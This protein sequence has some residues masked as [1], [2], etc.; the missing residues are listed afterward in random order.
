MQAKRPFLCRFFQGIR[1]VRR[2]TERRRRTRAYRD[3]RVIHAIP[4]IFTRK[5]PIKSRTFARII[6][7]LHGSRVDAGRD[8]PENE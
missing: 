5:L 7:E 8:R 1:F 2:R 3:F 4:R 6:S